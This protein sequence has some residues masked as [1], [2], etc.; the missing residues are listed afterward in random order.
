MLKQFYLCILLAGTFLLAKCDKKDNDSSTTPVRL[1]ITNASD[2]DMDNVYINSNG[3]E[4]DFGNIARGTTTSYVEFD[5][6]YG[7]A[8]V[9]LQISGDTLRYDPIDYIGDLGFRLGKFTYELSVFDLNA[10][11][12]SLRL[13]ADE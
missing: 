13:I 7:K 6:I 9:I 3:V 1:R 12:L 11:V 2:F 5:T 4:H 10:K 8:E